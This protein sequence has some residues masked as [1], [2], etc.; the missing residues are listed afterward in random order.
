MVAILKSI[1]DEFHMQFELVAQLIKAMAILFGYHHTN[2][3]IF[4]AVQ[5]KDRCYPFTF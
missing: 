5:G 3:Q 2:C 4:L 1:L